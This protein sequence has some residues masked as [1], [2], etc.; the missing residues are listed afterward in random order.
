[1]NNPVKVV[2]T[3]I[4][5]DK[6]VRANDVSLYLANL[7]IYDDLDVKEHLKYIINEFSKPIEE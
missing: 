6:Y 7:L 3:E 5:G 2:T 4:Y 1:M